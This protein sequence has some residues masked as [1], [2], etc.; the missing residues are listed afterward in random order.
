MHPNGLHGPNYRFIRDNTTQTDRLRAG[1]IHG[2]CTRVFF[3]IASD[4]VV[5]I[6]LH[7]P[8]T[9][10]TSRICDVQVMGAAL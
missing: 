9:H 3:G 10:D 7:H 5:P 2:M 8:R 4:E 1:A 6:A